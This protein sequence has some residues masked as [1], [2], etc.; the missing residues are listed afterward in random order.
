M[1]EQLLDN[2]KKVSDKK[3]KDKEEELK[4]AVDF[5]KRQ[6]GLVK[7]QSDV[8]QKIYRGNLRQRQELLKQSMAKLAVLAATAMDPKVAQVYLDMF[9]K[10]DA[11]LKGLSN[12]WE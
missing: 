4:Q 8:E 5:A 11:Q 10:L 3:K 7:T 6:A 12:T 1:Q 2:A 9:D